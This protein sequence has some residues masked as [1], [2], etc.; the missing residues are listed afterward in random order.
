[1]EREAL[2]I[3]RGKSSRAKGIRGL[4][5]SSDGFIPVAAMTAAELSPRSTARPA[6]ARK[7]P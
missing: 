1:M 6:L 7:Y 3:D 2:Q 4:E 5:F